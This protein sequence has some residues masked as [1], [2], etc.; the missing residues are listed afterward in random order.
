[1]NAN[2]ILQFWFEEIEQSQWFMA[3]AD[4][5]QIIQQRFADIHLQAQRGELYSWRATSKG[6]LAE[7]IILDQFSRNMFRNTAQAFSCDSLALILAQEAISTGAGQALTSIERSFLYMP[8]MHSES[9]IIHNVAIALYQENGVQ[10]N[11]DFEIKHKVIIEKFG[12][13]PHRNKI[14]NRESTKEEIE[15]LTQAGSSF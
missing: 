13:Y 1:M 11:L 8:F 9:L 7:V 12:R 15:F 3:N 10:A 4:F 5:D 14:L 6:R 2:D